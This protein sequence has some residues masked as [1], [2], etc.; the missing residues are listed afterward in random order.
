MLNSTSVCRVGK[1]PQERGY[2]FS[3]SGLEGGAKFQRHRLFDLFLNMQ[4]RHEAV[5]LLS[6][7]KVSL[8]YIVKRRRA[9]FLL[10]LPS[11]RFASHDVFI[12]EGHPSPLCDYRFVVTIP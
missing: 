12:W 5:L 6:R 2:K 10:I 4:P 1:Q 3:D 11:I 9:A 8:Y 7:N